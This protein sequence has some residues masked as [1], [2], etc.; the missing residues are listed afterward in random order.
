MIDQQRKSRSHCSQAN[1][2]FIWIA[3]VSMATLFFLSFFLFFFYPLRATL[4]LL[5]ITSMKS[6]IEIVSHDMR[7]ERNP[8][9]PVPCS[10]I[11]SNID[12]IKNRNY[13]VKIKKKKKTYDTSCYQHIFFKLFHTFRNWIWLLITEELVNRMPPGPYSQLRLRL[14]LDFALQDFP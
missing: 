2:A 9:A 10:I 4:L 13:F 3:S 6:T 5:S 7:P 11:N 12:V 8:I 14:N 1:A